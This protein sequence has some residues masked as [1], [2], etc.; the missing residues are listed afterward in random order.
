MVAKGQ[1]QLNRQKTVRGMC[2]DTNNVYLGYYCGHMGNYNCQKQLRFIPKMS[3]LTVC[4]TSLNID[5]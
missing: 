3:V 2:G 5:D 1:S 4:K